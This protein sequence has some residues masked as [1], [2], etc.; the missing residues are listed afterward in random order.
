MQS[1]R[2]TQSY[3]NSW[4]D[5]VLRVSSL[6][7]TINDEANFCT[8]DSY[9]P[10]DPKIATVLKSCTDIIPPSSKLKSSNDSFLKKH[11]SSPR[12]VV[13]GLRV[14]DSL[15]AASKAQ[16]EKDLVKVLGLPGVSL[17]DV[18]LALS[19]LKEWKSS[20]EA[21]R[22]LKA[23]ARRKWPEANAFLER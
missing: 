3:T 10:S 2:N 1:T 14:R 15:D 21:V 20:E 5:S 22:Q 17:S 23:E 18:D 8:V 13:S 19:V 9:K 6:W 11:H 12:H 16:N 4:V 7:P